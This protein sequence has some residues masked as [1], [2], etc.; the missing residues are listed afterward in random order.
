MNAVLTPPRFQLPPLPTPRKDYILHFVVGSAVLHALFLTA[1]FANEGR[2]QFDLG[3]KPLQVVLVNARSRTAPA[4]A[5]AL[6]QANLDHGGNTDQKIQATTPFPAVRDAEPQPE[7]KQ[8]LQ[9]VQQ[10]E[11]Q[12][13]RLLTQIKSPTPLDKPAPLA[14]PQAQAGQ[15][16]DAADL[17][18]RSLEMARLEAQ[19]ERQHRAYQERPRRKNIGARTEEYRFARYVEDW[20]LKVERVGNLNYPEEARQKKLYGSLL[21]SIAIKADGSLERVEVDRSSGSKILDE[22]AKRI[23]QMAAP[24]APFPEDIKREFEVIEISRTWTFTRSDQLV[25]Q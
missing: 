18:A 8:Q 4:K 25:A 12:Q 21:L 24:Y 1:H 16:P 11:Q 17:V 13:A 5:D 7:L 3:A 2:K 9:R 19:I 14:R 23:V 6:A 15:T 20:R 22:A 10:L